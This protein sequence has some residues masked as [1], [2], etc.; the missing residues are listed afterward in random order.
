MFA[1]KAG[2]YPSEAIFTCSTQVLAL[3]ANIRLGWKGFPGTNTIAYYQKFITY[4][5]KK[6]FNIGH[7]A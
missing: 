3:P 6:S 1:G 7:R 4:G 5:L 2:V